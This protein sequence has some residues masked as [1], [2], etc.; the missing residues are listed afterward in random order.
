M[1]K[2]GIK[3]LTKND[4]SW[5]KPSSKSHQAGM[6]L[7]LGQFSEMFPEIVGA[8]GSPRVELIV[9]WYDSEGTR[10]GV[11]DNE[12]VWYN[13]KRELRLLKIRKETFSELARTGSLIAIHRKNEKLQIRAIPKS[14]E[15]ILSMFQTLP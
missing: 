4:H 14:L 6:N 2:A 8:E 7:P 9:S 15:P 3:R 13:S 1:G 5:L 12:V 11:T 10:I